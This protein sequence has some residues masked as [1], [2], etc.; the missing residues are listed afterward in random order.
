MI[1]KVVSALGVGHDNAVKRHVLARRLGVTDRKMRR[2]IEA[3]RQEGWQI[4][5]DGD[6]A[7]YY[8]ATNLDELE[9]HYRVERARAIKTLYTLKPIRAY[10]RE[11]GRL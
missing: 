10:L 4:L 1:P 9:R 2:M 7:G 5:N 6:G 11:R 3:A 8:L